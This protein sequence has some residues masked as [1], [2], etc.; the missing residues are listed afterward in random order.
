MLSKC[1]AIYKKVISVSGAKHCSIDE[2]S[3]IRHDYTSYGKIVH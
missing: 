1:N 3:K 2:V